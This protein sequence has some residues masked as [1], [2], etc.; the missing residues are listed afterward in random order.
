MSAEIN[1]NA[2]QKKLFYLVCISFFI[3]GIDQLTKTYV[4]TQLQLHESKMIIENFFNLT[5][6]RNFGAAFGFLSQTP[7]LFREIFFLSMPPIACVLILYILSTLKQNQTAQIVALS[8][9]FGGALGNYID[10]LHYK[11]VV[12]FIDLRIHTHIWPAFNI[13]DMAIVTGV[14][15]LIYLILMEKNVSAN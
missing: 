8:S 3:I 5:Y 6:V 10:R 12:D 11:Y 13:A 2:N 4:H 15:M 9:I 7:Q 14:I 1:K